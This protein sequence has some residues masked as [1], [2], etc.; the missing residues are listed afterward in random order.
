MGLYPLYMVEYKVNL[1]IK[2]M[3]HWEETSNNKKL[4]WDGVVKNTHPH[5]FP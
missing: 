1:D 4:T 3:A 2:N 5:P